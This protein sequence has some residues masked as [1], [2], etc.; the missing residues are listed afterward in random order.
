MGEDLRHAEI[1]RKTTEVDIHVSLTLEGEGLFQGG[2]GIS[3]LDHMLV[4]L[5]KH[6]SL[7]LS[8]KAQGDLKHHLIEDVGIAVGQ[9]YSKAL[10]ERRGIRRFGFAYI[11]MDDALARAVVDLGGRSYPL[12]ELNTVRPKVEDLAVEDLEHF[13]TS[14][15]EHLK[16]N[17]H[18][19]V[20]YGFNDHHKVEA[21]VKA[22]ALALKEATTIQRDR[23]EEIPSTKGTL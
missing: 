19:E 6:S 17:V 2:T 20:L 22:L 4:I 3:F 8:V 12:I 15:T 14:L 23:P 18:I 9:A 7:D 1:E 13:F 5:C 11:P 21:A 16:A 10:Q